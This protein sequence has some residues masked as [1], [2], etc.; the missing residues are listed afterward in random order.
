MS[1][2]CFSEPP[3]EPWGAGDEILPDIVDHWNEAARTDESNTGQQ[4][5]KKT[6]NTWKR[7]RALN[8][9]RDEFHQAAMLMLEER[10]LPQT[11]K[12]PELHDDG[13][14]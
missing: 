9:L 7:P 13:V 4:R 12:A 14:A 3:L 5:S 2:W 1:A 8:G 10:M 11:P 6:Q